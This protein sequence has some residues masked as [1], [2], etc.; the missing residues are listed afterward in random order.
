MKRREFIALVG[1]AMAGWPLAA[2]AQQLAT[3]VIG[4]LSSG[5]LTER[6][7]LLAALRQGLGAAGYVE[8]QNVAIVY[9]SAEGQYDRLPSLA[10]ELVRQQVAVIVGLGGPAARAANAATTV[11]PIVFLFGEDPVKFDLVAS[12]NRP[13]GN[14]TGVSTFNAVLGSKRLGLLHELVPTATIIGLLLNPNY[15]S[16]GLE[17][18]ETQVAARAV[19]CG[20]IILN[21]STESNIDAAFASLVQQRVGAL[22]VTGD[23]FFVSRHDQIVALAA[24]HAVPTIYVQREFAAVGGLASYGTSLVEAYRQVGIYAGRILTG[25]KPGDLPVQ[26][27]TKFELVMNLKT[28]KTLGI[29]IPPSLLALADEVIE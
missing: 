29:T 28:A 11:I 5:S 14:M 10:V 3:P 24:R 8:G 15:P 27:P 17:I 13:G 12:L 9:R 23:P 4:I 25:D 21:A 26:Q 20:L 22:M 2:R 7:H 6:A 1:C 16:A 19:G 18:R